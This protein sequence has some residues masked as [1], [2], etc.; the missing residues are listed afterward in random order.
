V[1]ESDASASTE[2]TTADPVA[3]EKVAAVTSLPTRTATAPRRAADDVEPINLI[4]S[5]GPALAKR[6][7]PIVALVVLLILIARRRRH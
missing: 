4:E 3:E 2:P 7:A 5:A 6:L 1:P